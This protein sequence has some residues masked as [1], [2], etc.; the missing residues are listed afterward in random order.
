MLDITEPLQDL[1]AISD[2]IAKMWYHG[3]NLS[4][5][6]KDFKEKNPTKFMP[7]VSS[8]AVEVFLLG[9]L[10]PGHFVLRFLIFSVCL[11]PA[12]EFYIGIEKL[13]EVCG[14]ALEALLSKVNPALHSESLHK[15]QEVLAQAPE[16][17][18][19]SSS[20]S[21]TPH[22]SILPS[23]LPSLTS[24]VS[25]EALSLSK[26]SLDP[27]F[28]PWGLSVTAGDLETVQENVCGEANDTKRD[29]PTFAIE[30]YQGTG[31]YEHDSQS[32]SEWEKDFAISRSPSPAAIHAAK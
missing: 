14:D 32:E 7:V 27:Q 24:N 13:V 30:S 20:S 15:P 23:T 29:L 2:C 31:N 5:K 21:A 4:L 16:A 6:L 9:F 11:I 12:M 26:F 22:C 8:V 18:T 19:A 28:D 17:R 25:E 10:V 1:S 3:S